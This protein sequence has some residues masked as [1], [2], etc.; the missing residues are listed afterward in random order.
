MVAG[1]A[2]EVASRTVLAKEKGLTK[3]VL[4][5]VVPAK[6]AGAEV[7]VADEVAE[8]VVVVAATGADTTV[9]TTTAEGGTWAGA[10]TT[11]VAV[12]NLP[13]LK[14]MLVFF[15]LPVSLL[16]SS[17]C[18]L[19]SVFLKWQESIRQPILLPP[20]PAPHHAAPLSVTLT[21]TYYYRWM[22]CL[23]IKSRVQP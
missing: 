7:A 3:A 5:K 13:D 17:T 8:G 4:A 14:T 15:F 2:G 10:V 19:S 16:S 1:L 9:A 20:P 11:E 12:P 22:R 23:A 21:C 18:F 6:V